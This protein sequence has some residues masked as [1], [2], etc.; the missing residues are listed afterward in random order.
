MGE[1][2]RE[3]PRRVALSRSR[4]GASAEPVGA[5]LARQ[6]ALRGITLEELERRTRIP[7]RSLERLESGVFDGDR[8]AFARGF[9]RTVAMAIGVDGETAV[10][11]MDPE[12]TPGARGR[13]DRRARVGLLLAGLAIS[14]GLGLAIALFSGRISLPSFDWVAGAPRP[15]VYRTDA[16]ADLAAE[17][18]QRRLRPAPAL[19]RSLTEQEPLTRT[20][21]RPAVPSRASVPVSSSA[22]ARSASPRPPDRAAP[23]AS[24]ALQGEAGAAPQP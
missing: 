4:A 2:L 22:P 21:A 14:A 16:L 9:V 23:P 17:E 10:A 11:R 1:A 5:W 7:R 19:P 13:G 3:D 6:R 12:H 24:A 18:Q 20:D 15:V 8:D